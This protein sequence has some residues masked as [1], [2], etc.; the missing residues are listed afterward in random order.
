MKTLL[1]YFSATGN[2][3]TTARAIAAAL[4]DCTL[5]P[6]AALKDEEEVRIPA[7]VEKVGFVYP[8]YYSDM[9][10]I[11]RRV[12]SKMVF[13]GTPYIFSVCTCAGH[14]G[15]VSQ[16][17]NALLQ[18]RG[19][20]LSRHLCMYLPGN[21]RVHPPEKDA[22]QLADQES[23]TAALIQQLT[24]WTVEDHTPKEEPANS[25][26]HDARNMRGLLAEE[27]CTGCGT[28]VQVC[29]MYNVSLKDGRAAMGDE[30]VSCLACYHWC[31]QKAIIMS[32]GEPEMVRRRQ[33]RHP[34]VTLQD[35][36]A[37]KKL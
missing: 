13:E 22:Q 15:I 19:Q 26:V 31:P 23:A 1:F 4:E 3:L 34:A 10:H 35:I 28:C 11:L 29:P 24:E 25:P 9:P 21:S 33:Y 17:M 8:V 18:T 7:D 12:I 14:F 36:L 30:C 27:N 37:Q 20:K 32:T 5:V 16:R 6:V 2:S